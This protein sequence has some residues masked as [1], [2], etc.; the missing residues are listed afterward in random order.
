VHIG[1]LFLGASSPAAD[2]EFL[3]AESFPFAGEAARL[4]YA[5]GVRGDGKSA[6][7]TLVEFQR[8]G[9]LLAHML[10]CPLET[11]VGD[12]TSLLREHFDVVAARIRRSLKPK[13][14]VL[15]SGLLEPLLG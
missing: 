15:I 8:R 4:L 9:F 3:Y 10:E 12:P 7:A 11:V 6:E 2:A 14:I 5:T 1:T 13:K